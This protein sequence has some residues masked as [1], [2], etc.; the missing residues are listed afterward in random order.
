MI[1][2]KTS[3]DGGAPTVA[4]ID[5]DEVT[6]QLLSLMLNE[7]YNVLSSES[8][9]SGL[10]LI[11][12]HEIDVI[13]LDW[14]MPRMD[15]LSLLNV[16]K[17]DESTYNI[18]VIFISGVAESDSIEMAINSGAADFIRKPFRKDE[19]LAAIDNTLAAQVK[20]SD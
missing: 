1:R 12:Q 6:V 19:L 4:I 7:S 11:H 20:S 9:S 10:N 14:I 13:L 8:A 5:D 16:L 17:H 2:S 15:G 3:F 18:P